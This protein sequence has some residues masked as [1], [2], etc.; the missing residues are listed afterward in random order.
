[1]PH[2]FMPRPDTEFTSWVQ[3]LL[4]YA[5]AHTADL[6]LLPANITPLSTALGTWMTAYP[7]H[8]TALENAQSAREAKDAARAA[9]ELAVRAL[10][11]R[12][13]A[14]S[15]VS[16]PEK[17]ALGIT[18]R[19]T[20]PTPVGPPVTRP[21]GQVDT[22]QRLSHLVGFRDQDQPH[23]LAKPGGV[24]ACE[25]WV[26]IGDPAPVDPSDLRFLATDS[27]T[28]Y[29]AEYEGTDAGKTAHYML[30]WISTRNEPGP[31]SETISATIGG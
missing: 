11:K 21:V 29:V 30:R 22:S 16:D 14:A 10:V 31:W 5:S 24:M 3:N 2:D 4:T 13:Q 6:G 20:E 15:A 27:K 8:V 12:L 17:Q 7:A 28:P 1:M 25:I 9:L 26:K 23:S 19:D 18:V